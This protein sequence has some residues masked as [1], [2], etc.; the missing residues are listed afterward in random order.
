MH[1]LLNFLKTFNKPIVYAI[2]LSIIGIAFIFLPRFILDV[3]MTVIG[4]LIIVLSL[5]AIATLG[6][7]AHTSLLAL[8][9]R[10]GSLLSSMLVLALGV[11][12]VTVRS[13]VT[14]TLCDIASAVLGLYAVFSIIRPSH[15][16]AEQNTAWWLRT[17]GYVLIA[18]IGVALSVIPISPK[19]TAGAIAIVIGIVIIVRT[20]SKKRIQDGTNSAQ[21]STSSDYYTTDFIDKSE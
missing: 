16:C 20:I 6:E 15:R 11:I 14:E 17:A 3:S 8:F 2:A 13:S 21:N 9:T 5:I 4:V 18:L 1:K 12:L 7:G 10:G 19:I